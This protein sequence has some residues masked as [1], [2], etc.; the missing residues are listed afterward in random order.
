[1]KRRLP[2]NQLAAVQHA[3]VVR[4][5]DLV[6]QGDAKANN[7]IEEQLRQCPEAFEV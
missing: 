6:M 3:R 1:M 5:L 2:R 4:E 7:L